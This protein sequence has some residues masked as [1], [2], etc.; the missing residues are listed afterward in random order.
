[1]IRHILI[2][3]IVISIVWLTS[4]AATYFVATG[5]DDMGS[6]TIDDPWRTI[7]KAADSVQAGDSVLVRSGNYT[8]DVFHSRS[9]SPSHG[10]IVFLNFGDE[11]VSLDPGSF[12]GWN[13]SY[14]KIE[15]FHILSTTGEKPGI[16]FHGTGG[17]VEIIG[18]EITGVNAVNTA[19]LRIGGWMHDFIIHGN[20]VHHN[21]TGNQ[22][23]IRVHGHT[24][25]F[26]VTNN[27]VN[28]N[29]NIGIDI[30]GWSQ[31]GKPKRGLV[32]GNLSDSNTTLAD[33]AAGIYLD[34]P[35]SITVEYNVST[36][37][38]FGFQLGCEPDADSS[39][40]NIMRYNIAYGNTRYGLSLGGYTGG[41]VHH[42]QIYNNVFHENGCEIN[43]STNAGHDNLFV[44]NVLLN[45]SGQS[46]NYLGTPNNTVVDYNCYYTGYGDI[47]GIHS[48]FSN[49]RFE[50][51]DNH[52]YH[53]R[54]GSPCIDA[55]DPATAPG[56][57]FDGN[58]VP[59]DG[60]GDGAVTID[61]GAYE[62]MPAI[63]VFDTGKQNPSV[64]PHIESST[65]NPFH[66]RANIRF[67]LTR[68]SRIILIIYDI[69]GHRIRILAQGEQSAGCHSAIWDGYN[70]KG[71]RAPSGVYLCRLKTEEGYMDQHPLILAE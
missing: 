32:S 11:Y 34:G 28:H 38:R 69:R 13:T 50:D 21:Y 53:L 52:D 51:S 59:Q 60:D 30:V 31:F 10:S 26:A 5:G 25:D 22:E 4:H 3:F 48:I 56:L 36:G 20:H 8:E 65:P 18:N 70:Q 27:T 17:F 16:E 40:G 54:V 1:M 45:P 71:H 33:W 6:G 43:F 47:P 68:S 37:N 42:C 15:G 24:R 14:I 67:E 46:I 7:Q 23:G 64:S 55:G 58:R 49:P 19:A 12:H 39:K 63:G 41:T 35:D 57:D 29:V 62:Y 61:M 44:N 66:R 2:A 9:G